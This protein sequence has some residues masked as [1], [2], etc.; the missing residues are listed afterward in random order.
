MS[1][2]CIGG[3]TN[4]SVY[5]VVFLLIAYVSPCSTSHRSSVDPR[6]W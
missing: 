5:L 1:L 4:A 3:Q 6:R 2:S